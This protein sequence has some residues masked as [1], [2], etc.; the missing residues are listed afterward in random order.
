[1]EGGKRKVV[2][3]VVVWKEGKHVWCRKPCENPRGDPQ[4]KYIIWCVASLNVYRGE[5]G[6]ER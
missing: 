5:Y 1:M 3:F 6:R 2:V 4:G